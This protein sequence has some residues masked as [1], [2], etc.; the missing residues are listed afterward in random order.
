MPTNPI[1][2]ANILSAETG[3]PLNEHTILVSGQKLSGGSAT[4]GS[5]QSNI[6]TEQQINSLFG[7]KSHIA[8]K[9]RAVL[10]NLSISR[11]KPKIDAIA[12]D[13]DGASV[14]ASKTF[15]FAGTATESK[16]FYINVNDGNRYPV[17]V[18]SGEGFAAIVAKAEAVINANLDANY[19]ASINA[20]Q[21]VITGDNG[22]TNGNN[23]AVWFEGEVAGVTFPTGGVAFNGIFAE[24]DIINS[25]FCAYR[26]L[27]FTPNSNVSSINTGNGQTTGGIRWGSIPYFNMPFANLPVIESKSNVFFLENGATDPSLTSVFDNVDGIQYK[28]IDYPSAWDLTTLSNFTKPRFNVDNKVL[29]SQGFTFK[30]DTYANLNTLLD[31]LNEKTICV[32]FNPNNMLSAE[33]EELE[34][35]GGWTFENNNA[36]TTL[37]TRAVKTTYK[38]N[39]LGNPDPTFI[40][41][42]RVDSLTIAREYHFNGIKTTYPRH[43]LTNADVAPSNQVAFVTKGG[44]IATMVRFYNDLVEVGIFEG[45]REAEY[46]ERIFDTI[47]FDLLN[48]KITSDAISPITSQLREV[49]ID[50]L[51]VLN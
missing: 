40:F 42:N 50:F 28:T 27:L 24:N 31:G 20:N 38:T 21:L 35:S 18:I 48:G 49:T 39:D 51:S 46:A 12:L 2:T 29:Y 7:R 11:V 34:S 32:G 37:L 26:G 14:K 4:S 1:V 36:N 15:V 44:F 25:Q 9:L 6:I 5:L 17:S 23:I 8:K 13:D 10:K 30:S 3:V 47:N 43:T 16:V 33:I 41:L 45:G 19:T 22:G